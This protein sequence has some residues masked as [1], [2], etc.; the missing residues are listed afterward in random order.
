[1]INDEKHIELN[2]HH[3]CDHELHPLMRYQPNW[4]VMLQLLYW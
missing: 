4:L 2:S 3:Y 1:M